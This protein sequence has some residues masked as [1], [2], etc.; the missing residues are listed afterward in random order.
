MPGIMGKRLRRWE[1]VGWIAIGIVGPLL[2]FVYEWSGRNR[3]IAA[4]SAVNESVWEH[5]KILFFPLLLLLLMELGVFAGHYRNFLAV[6]LTAILAGLITV[7]TLFYTYS[8]VLGENVSSID[9]AIYYIAA[10]ISGITTCILAE[11]GK[12]VGTWK[13]VLAFLGLLILG[14]FFVW[15]TY[16]T[17]SLGIFRGALLRCFGK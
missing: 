17:P 5:M 8:G 16:Y 14:F 11:R 1:I 13:Q 9:V 7:P 6:K 4:V 10:A 2:H 3:V 12:L 15:F